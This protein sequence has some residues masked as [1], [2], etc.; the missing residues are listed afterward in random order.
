MQLEINNLNTE[1][2]NLMFK[3]NSSKNN[4][5][6]IDD[7]LKRNSSRYM[8]IEKNYKVLD[9]AKN[10]LTIL[11][12]HKME[13]KKEFIL[14][15]INTALHDVFEQNIKIDI[16]A[17]STSTDNGKINMKYDII[18]SQNGV[19]MARNEKLLGNNGG[20]V[21]SFVSI[22][23]KMIV[24]YIYSD[25]KFYL[26]DESISQVSP[27]YRPKLAKFLKQFCEEYGFTLVLISQTDDIDDFA[28]MVY[29]LDGKFDKDGIPEL[30]IKNIYGQYPEKDYVYSKIENFQS[31]VKQ[32]FRYKGFT[33]IR[34][35]NN[36]GKSASFRA[37]NAILFN[38][39]DAKDHPRKKR[40]KGQNP[41]IEFGKY[42]DDKVDNSI[43]LEYNGTKVVYCFD[44]KEYAGKTLAF[45]KVKE[46]VQEIGFKYVNLKETYKNFK[47][48]LK[49]QTERLALTT[50]YDSFY[51]IGSKANETEK[52]F[53]FLFDSTD[54]ANAIS[55]ISNDMLQLNNE[56][57]MLGN[58]IKL[59]EKILSSETLQE[60][61]LTYKYYI[62]YIE[63]Y[64]VYLELY[65]KYNNN[66]TRLKSLVEN[67]SN[68]ISLNENIETL[69]QH[70]SNHFYYKDQYKTTENKI[71]KIDQ[72]CSSYQVIDNIKNYISYSSNYSILIDARAT[73]SNKINIIDKTVER[74]PEIIQSINSFKR[75]YDN[76]KKHNHDVNNLIII[77]E[78]QSITNTIIQKIDK[79]IQM[80]EYHSWLKSSIVSYIS[81]ISTLH[82]LKISQHNK[83]EEITNLAQIMQ[84]KICPTCNGEGHCE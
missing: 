33:V 73:I 10:I 62:V 42:S 74:Y 52:V 84:I 56:F 82:N 23:F 30:F 31:I 57:N 27:D 37:I 14:N 34:G 13:S 48:N 15:T 51:L 40:K 46:K 43:S 41:K 81:H 18:L 80:I 29:I 66:K 9:D 39:F 61:I 38:D 70:L 44:G 67:Y 68:Y 69:K 25:N 83:L 11:K 8:E 64:K 49:D 1:L 72:I 21:L 12:N 20:G 4:I 5:S 55:Q 53:N 76:I 17:T 22:L 45:E 47:G 79:L 50:Q 35:R 71:S 60:K 24:G 19:E 36:I 7:K 26:F 78:Q 65:N 59:D 77:K 54:V 16:E 32:E 2:S 75:Q 6:I 58:A 28:D 63:L 3:L